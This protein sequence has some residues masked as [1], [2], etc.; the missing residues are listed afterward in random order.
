MNTIIIDNFFS[1][2][3]NI[4]NEFKKIK[5]YDFGEYNKMTSNN[6][7]K[8]IWP[9]KRS[10]YIHNEN[11]FLFN[12]SLKELFEKWKDV[13]ETPKLEFKTVLHLRL[14]ED[15][16]KDFIHYDPDDLTMIVYLSKTNLNSGTAIYPDNSD[17]PETIVKFVQNRCVIFDSKKRHRSLNNHGTNLDNGRLTLNTFLTIHKEIQ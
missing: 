15:E 11:P 14:D 16:K 7:S 6:D 10:L 4:K 3:H 13:E 17:E 5:L 12:L 8:T 2:F 1:N 9:G